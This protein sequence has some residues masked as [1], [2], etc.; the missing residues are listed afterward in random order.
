[1]KGD[2]YSS[3]NGTM[4]LP[5]DNCFPKPA[6]RLAGA[7]DNIWYTSPAFFMPST[8]D[9]DHDQG[10]GLRYFK[11]ITH[12]A[13]CKFGAWHD[14]SR[15]EK[16]YPKVPTESRDFNPPPFVVEAHQKALLQVDC[17]QYGPTMG[18]ARLKTAIANMY[19]PIYDK[20]IDGDKNICIS[21]GA[22]AAILSSLMAFIEVGDEVIVIEPLFNLYEY[23]IDFVGGS[24]KSVA[25]HPPQKTGATWTSADDWRLDI[26]ELR[27]AIS[28]RTKM[29]IINTP[30]NPLGKVYRTHELRSIGELCV[31]H[32]III[33]SD[34]VYEHLYYTTSFPRIATLS[35]AIA[36]RTIT[37]GSVG[38]SFN[39]T[40]WRVG[41]AIGDENL[42]MHVKWA[43]VLLSY[44]TPGP[45]QEA[46]AVAYEKAD[47]EGFWESNKQLFK[48][49]VDRLCQFLDELGLPYVVPSG[50]YFIF[51]NICCLRLPQDYNF[52]P[53]ITKKGQDCRVCYYM[54][55]E[56]GV[57][58]IPGS[59]E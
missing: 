43:Q 47:S 4:S 31:G 49:K 44:V 11:Q 7:V 22:T 26:E 40:G 1:M 58:S 46:A 25:L 51:V 48:H 52:P 42:I 14:V 2:L 20:P 23:L 10:M 15:V 17:N 3:L 41:Y 35:T 57:S 9:H 13:Y 16:Q 21:T 37:I 27:N 18:R 29:L 34:E 5:E 19:W 56:L 33:L 39:A 50:A 12:P 59:G 24:V 36:A 54:C 8:T 38:K 53:T 30:H 32:N 28:P 6:K 55:Q 45:A